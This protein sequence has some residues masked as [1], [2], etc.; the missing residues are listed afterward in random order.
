MRIRCMEQG[1]D[2]VFSVKSNRSHFTDLLQKH[3]K[4]HRM[5]RSPHTKQHSAPY[6]FS[7]FSTS[8]ELRNLES[9]HTLKLHTGHTKAWQK[10]S[11]ACDRL[12]F[13]STSQTNHSSPSPRR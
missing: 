8:S 10:S 12:A 1:M 5:Q 6:L 3:G 9:P 2:L 11:S 13:C 7:S 4:R